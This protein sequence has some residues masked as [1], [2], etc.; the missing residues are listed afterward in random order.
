MKVPHLPS[1]LQNLVSTAQLGAP[2]QLCKPFQESAVTIEGLI[3]S[4]A[5]SL[6]VPPEFKLH[7]PSLG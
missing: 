5:V 3:L 1:C 7:A 4:P 2:H 6:K